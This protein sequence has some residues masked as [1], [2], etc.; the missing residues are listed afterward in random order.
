M[1]KTPRK[2]LRID[3]FIKSLGARIRNIREQKKMSIEQLAI[4]CNL[5]YYH[6]LTQF[7]FQEFA[8]I[9]L[10][11]FFPLNNGKARTTIFPNQTFCCFGSVYNNEP[12]HSKR[13]KILEYL[14]EDYKQAHKLPKCFV[15]TDTEIQR[16]YWQIQSFNYWYFTIQEETLGNTHTGGSPV[17]LVTSLKKV[18]ERRITS[19]EEPINIKQI[20]SNFYF[21]KALWNFYEVTQIRN[22]DN[23][24]VW[25]I[26]YYQGNYDN[27][28][29]IPSEEEIL[30]SPKLLG[31]II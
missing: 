17:Y 27:T 30:S 4:E 5:E 20:E 7:N 31:R 24:T 29:M 10:I 3:P 22:E 15:S 21:E 28:R 11:I 9:S 1:S 19:K 16:K 8:T 14:T 6:K 25:Y 23:L 26:T 2:H 18:G 12:I 13:G